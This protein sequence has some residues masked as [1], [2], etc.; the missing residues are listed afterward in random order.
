M[1]VPVPLP[2]R[3]WRHSLSST[4]QS[5]RWR[6]CGIVHRVRRASLA[7]QASGRGGVD[8]SFIAWHNDEHPVARARAKYKR[9]QQTTKE[10]EGDSLPPPPPP[11]PYAHHTESACP[12]RLAHRT[13]LYV[14]CPASVL[15]SSR[16]TNVHP[17]NVGVPFFVQLPRSL[18]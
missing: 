12:F 13:S 2:A 8:S 14:A 15:P 18:A 17:R 16:L 6:I 4:D 5:H 7:V 9:K 3:T 10:D 11:P 1:P